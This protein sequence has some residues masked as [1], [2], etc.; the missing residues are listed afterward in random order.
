MSDLAVFI[1][2][3]IVVV[4]SMRIMWPTR[5]SNSDEELAD[6]LRQIADELDPKDAKP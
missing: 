6:E 5:C 3:V 4:I 2:F 1:I